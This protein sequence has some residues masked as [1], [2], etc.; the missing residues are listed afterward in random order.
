MEMETEMEM[1][2]ETEMEKEMEIEW[3]WEFTRH[4]CSQCRSYLHYIAPSKLQSL[5]NST[6]ILNK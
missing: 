6:T 2:I 5:F 1:E 3:K 4:S